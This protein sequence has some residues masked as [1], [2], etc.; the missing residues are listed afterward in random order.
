MAGSTLGLASPL[1]ASGAAETHLAAIGVPPAI[2][3]RAGPHAPNRGAQVI[4]LLLD[5]CDALHLEV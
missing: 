1:E 2:P 5:L 3:F 4:H